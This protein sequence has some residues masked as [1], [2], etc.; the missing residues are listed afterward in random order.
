MYSNMKKV[1]VKASRHLREDMRGRPR[2][3][4]CSMAT[5]LKR[6][7]ICKNRFTSGYEVKTSVA[8]GSA[9]S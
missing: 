3:C 2:N 1:Y 7:K 8:L 5:W 6:L 9:A 4:V